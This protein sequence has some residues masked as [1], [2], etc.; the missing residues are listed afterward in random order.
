MSDTNLYFAV[1]DLN[2]LL[3]VSFGIWFTLVCFIKMVATAY[4][5]IRSDSQE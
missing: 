5:V 3:F 1:R 4:W 2:Y